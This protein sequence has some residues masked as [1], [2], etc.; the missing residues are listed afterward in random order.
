MTL[1]RQFRRD[2]V[3]EIAVPIPELV[4]ELVE[5]GNDWSGDEPSVQQTIGVTLI[6]ATF[7]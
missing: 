2:I 5:P 7:A 6:G 1:H 3:R 4:G